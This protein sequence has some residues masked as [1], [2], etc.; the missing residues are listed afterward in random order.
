MLWQTY[1]RVIL[2][3]IVLQIVHVIM[4]IKVIVT[5]LLL[6]MMMMMKTTSKRR[7]NNNK[8]M[9]LMRLWQAMNRVMY[10]CSNYINLV[11]RCSYCCVVLS[12]HF[13]HA[14]VMGCGST[15]LRWH[16]CSAVCQQACTL[17]QSSLTIKP[18]SRND[19]PSCS[20]ERW[21]NSPSVQ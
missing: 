20:P 4:N 21:C 11:M 18:I 2:L 8:K 12:L 14:Y 7:R 13:Y 10:Y 15:F 19:S 17:T 1:L 3:Q 9:S 6:V 5:L 16:S